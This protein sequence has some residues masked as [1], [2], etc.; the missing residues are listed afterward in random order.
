MFKETENILKER[1]KVY[2]SKG[3]MLKKRGRVSTKRLETYK[4]HSLIFVI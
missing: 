1:L 2:T 3:K 4:L